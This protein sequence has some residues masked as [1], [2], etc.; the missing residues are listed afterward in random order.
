MAVN[1]D[2]Q[3]DKEKSKAKKP[4]ASNK[5]ISNIAPRFKNNGCCARCKNNNA[6]E[7]SI[8]CNIC[9]N[10]FHAH[11]RDTRGTPLNTSIC[12]KTFVDSFRPVSTKYG[13][14]SERWGNFVFICGDC[15]KNLKSLSRKKITVL[16]KQVQCEPCT[17]VSNE[18]N[19]TPTDT[20]LDGM[21]SIILSMKEDIIQ[22]VTNLIDSKL[23]THTV[24]KC[25]NDIDSK[26]IPVVLPHTYA[27]VVNDCDANPSNVAN[28]NVANNKDNKFNSD[29]VIV[30]NTDSQ[31]VDYPNIV[32]SIGN[33]L[34][35]V[36]ID[37]LKEKQSHGK[38]VIGFPSAEVKEKG[39]ELLATCPEIATNG[40]VVN[41]AKK[42]M[43]KITVTN[44]PNDIASD[45]IKLKQ[46]S[47]A[48]EYNQNLKSIFYQRII[49]KN[50]DIAQKIDRGNQIF[51]IVYVNV[52]KDYSTLG[53]KVS[54]ELRNIIMTKGLI[55][56][57]NSRCK[58]LDR[59]DVK[60]CFRCQKFG[61]ISTNCSE[62]IVCMYCSA[63]HRS[64]HCTVKRNTELHR[65]RNCAQS[66]NP[67]HKSSCNTH[68]SASNKC[69]VML[70]EILRLKQHTE[71]SKNLLVHPVPN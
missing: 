16:N 18:T 67:Q 17:E 33:K 62:D 3:A 71:Y 30:L 24:E 45:I 4:K 31:N 28:N 61:H 65:C 48:S 40:F 5:G 53:I 14:N 66:K 58:V 56:I 27:T 43:P 69:P 70:K 29:D 1:V 32:K 38:I 51:D 68:H 59:F 12:T 49:E 23:A 9:E 44:I 55:Y 54:L 20:T 60:Q 8:T 6:I 35:S 22:H 13:S 41:D 46:S 64:S 47:S 37:F 26:S 15:T 7:E 11:C 10:M 50:H 42:M 34:T 21:K 63:S 52:G 25:T 57:G 19:D 39:K 36:P 2:D